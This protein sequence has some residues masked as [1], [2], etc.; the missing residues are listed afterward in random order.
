VI[1]QCATGHKFVNKHLLTS[2]RT[3]T[4]DQSKAARAN[5]STKL[6][7][8]KKQKNKTHATRVSEDE[9]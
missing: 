5:S 7:K 2:N 6:H 4:P 3:Q 8:L 9:F 1:P